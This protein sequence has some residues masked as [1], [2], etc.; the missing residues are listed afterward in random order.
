MESMKP[1]MGEW[2]VCD[3]ISIMG[4][5][6]CQSAYKMTP[7]LIVA[8]NV[9]PIEKLHTSG[10]YDRL[11]EENAE[12]R[13]MLKLYKASSDELTKYKHTLSY[14]ESYAGESVGELKNN[15]AELDMVSCKALKLLNK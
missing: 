5:G 13:E 1:K 6:D 14:N 9:K 7:G 3:L 11:V 2:W 12:L 15:L 10:D 4:N 8:G